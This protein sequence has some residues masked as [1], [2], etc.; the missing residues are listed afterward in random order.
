MRNTKSTL[1]NK[2]EKLP[3]F[4]GQPIHVIAILSIISLL[5]VF[6]IIALLIKLFAPQPRTYDEYFENIDQVMQVERDAADAAAVYQP[7][8]SQL[9][10]EFYENEVLGM[11]P[12]V[13][14]VGE[15]AVD[16]QREAIG[17]V[18]TNNAQVRAMGGIST[19]AELER[20]Y[21]GNPK[22]PVAAGKVQQAID[23]SQGKF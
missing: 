6:L 11:N 20:Y 23:A 14:Q 16:V 9:G 3:I 21:N 22:D 1:I 17:N 8:E 10:T 4:R 7:L 19:P 13:A 12:R 15:N 5:S 2:I 18:Q